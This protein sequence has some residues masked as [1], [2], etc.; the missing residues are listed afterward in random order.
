MKY[1]M[2]SGIILS[3]MGRTLEEILIGFPLLCAVDHESVC[4]ADCKPVGVS[5]IGKDGRCFDL[6]QRFTVSWPILRRR[7]SYLP[8]FELPGVHFTRG[9]IYAE[10]NQYIPVS[11]SI[12]MYNASF[13]SSA[14]V[15]C[16]L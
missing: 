13:P 7:N 6:V 9:D 8:P 12:S 10:A 5:F 11:Q 2:P 14:E 16:K 15:P 4:A 1:S 3:P